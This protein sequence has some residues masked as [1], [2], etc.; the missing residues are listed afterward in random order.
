MEVLL[1]VSLQNISVI[2]MLVSRLHQHSP[3]LLCRFVRMASEMSTDERTVVFADPPD[4]S[5]YT[6][7]RVPIKKLNQ[8]IMDVAF[9]Q[10]TGFVNFP[11]GREA[12]YKHHRFADRV[13][14]SEHWKYKYLVDFDGMGYSGRLFSF[15]ASDSAVIKSTVYKEYFSDYIQPW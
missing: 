8:G 6:F 13:P 10:S 1:L 4:S 15:L 7:A 14:L 9:V 12:L 3:H 11:G 5:D 2:G